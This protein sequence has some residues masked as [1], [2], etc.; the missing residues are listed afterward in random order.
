MMNTAA[1]SRLHLVRILAGL[2]ISL[3][4]CAQK[5]TAAEV[6][7]DLISPF[8]GTVA[9]TKS[10]TILFRSSQPLHA[11]GRLILLDGNDVT[12][13]VT[14]DETGYRF[15]APG[16]MPSGDHHLAIFASDLNGQPIEQEF[17]FTSRHSESFEEISS[18]NRL[19]TTAKTALF[20]DGDSGDS[21]ET[22][23]VAIEFPYSSLD[24]YLSSNSA[25]REGG[26]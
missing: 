4:L 6:K 14:E 13:M 18:E 1:R 16:P 10:P 26:W 11:E 24:A 2:T 15:T 21:A 5:T 3:A 12:A 17:V 9:I 8:P 19:S 22:A 23:P 25:I 7:I 20:R